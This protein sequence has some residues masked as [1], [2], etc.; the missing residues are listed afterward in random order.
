MKKL[1]L[2]FLIISLGAFAQNGRLMPDK[3]YA[4]EELKLALSNPQEHYNLLNSGNPII[5]DSA[6]AIEV[7]EPLLFSV[8]SKEKIEAQRPYAVCLLDG[9]WIISGTLPLQMRGGAFLIIMDSR[10]AQVVTIKHG[11]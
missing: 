6:T 5:Q 9:Y 1:F 7:A 10:N 11:R 4:E 8:F 2:V 3:K